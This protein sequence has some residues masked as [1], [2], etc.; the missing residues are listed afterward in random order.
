MT[1]ANTFHRFFRR[2]RPITRIY[3]ALCAW[4]IH[5]ARLC[6]ASIR[7]WYP[8]L[9]VS[10]LCDQ[11]AGP[12]DP[13]ALL[14]WPHV[15]YHPMSRPR[16]SVFSKLE[17]LFSHGHGRFLYLDA[18][19]VL[20]GPLLERLEGYDADFIV[21]PEGKDDS[22][23]RDLY[24]FDEKRLRHLDPDFQPPGF[25]FNAGQW[26][27]TGNIFRREEFDPWVDWDNGPCIRDPDT[28]KFQDQSLWNYLLF[29]AAASGRVSLND[30]PFYIYAPMASPEINHDTLRARSTP[31]SLVHWP[32]RK[33][34]NLDEM[35]RPDLLRFF[36]E[37]ARIIE[38]GL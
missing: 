30:V 8:R 29:K 36:D 31:P 20:I 17:P 11:G 21:S 14:R 26:V 38:A 28:F 6:L 7:Y 23:H 15:H 12:C 5:L 3:V 25:V 2:N 24:G 1:L 27:G 18:D 37:Q 35:A 22:A 10:L 32:G 13:G 33:S 16:L 34:T 9:P 19:I 4:D